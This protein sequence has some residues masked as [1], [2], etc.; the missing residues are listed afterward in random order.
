MRCVDTGDRKK[1]EKENL[2][3]KGTGKWR[4]V[5]CMAICS[6]L[7]LTACGTTPQQLPN[8][9]TGTIDAMPGNIGE[10]DV[11]SG[12]FQEAFRRGEDAVLKKHRANW[13]FLTYR[14]KADACYTR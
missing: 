14:A 11:S 5:M 8:T 10:E 6:I 13:C 3:M 4:G 7:L 2:A 12:Y 1:A 9:P